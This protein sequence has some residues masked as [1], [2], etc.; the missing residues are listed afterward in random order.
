MI[1][2]SRITLRVVKEP[3]ERFDLDR[4]FHKPIDIANF[5]NTVFEMDKLA[6]EKFV[7]VSLNTKNDVT[8]VFEISHGGLNASIVHPRDVFK[9]ALLVNANAIAFAHNHPSGNP[10]PSGEDLSIT[11]KLVNVGKIIGIKV[12][13]HVIIGDEGRYYSIRE[14]GNVSF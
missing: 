2:V 4:S 8:G 9:R 11:K 3:A 5:F 6:E 13:D 10:N 7:M 14:Q 1:N 12:L